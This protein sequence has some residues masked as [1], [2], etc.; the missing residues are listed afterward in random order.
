V[1]TESEGF[2]SELQTKKEIS[3]GVEVGYLKS[4]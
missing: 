3:N 1:W 4:N 2:V